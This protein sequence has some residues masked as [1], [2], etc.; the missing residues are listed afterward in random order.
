MYDALIL[1][2]G[3]LGAIAAII[4]ALPPL[5]IDV[6][7]FGRSPM[8]TGEIAPVRATPK[9]RWWLVFT[10]ACIA[11][12]GSGVGLSIEAGNWYRSSHSPSTES[13]IRITSQR[14]IPSDDPQLPFGWEVVIETDKE[15]SPVQ[16]WVICDGDIGKGH[17]RFSSGDEFSYPTEAVMNTGLYHPDVFN[18]KWARPEWTPGSPV[19]V[20]LFSKTP[21]R[22]LSV[23]QVIYRPNAP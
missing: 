14:K 22:A 17:G 4:A 12:A 9:G 21:I 3:A 7:V 1:L 10:V 11:L 5:G 23:T 16:L 13:G 19:E 6:R 20:Q 15:R 18:V 2:F 8:G